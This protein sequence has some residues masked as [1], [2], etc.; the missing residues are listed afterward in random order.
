M[1]IGNVL[2]RDEGV[3]IRVIERVVESVA[4]SM[5]GDLLE[6]LD[7]GTLSFSLAAKVGSADRLIV[8]DAANLDASPGTLCVFMDADMDTFLGTRK[9]S[10]HEVGLLDLMDMARLTEDLPPQRALVGIQ[11]GTIDWGSELTP[12]VRDRVDEARD[13]VLSLISNWGHADGFV[14]TRL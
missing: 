12:A 3:G 6:I 10:V 14:Q 13:A 1:G 8:V 9:R 4:D 2:L 7:A 11:P 5:H